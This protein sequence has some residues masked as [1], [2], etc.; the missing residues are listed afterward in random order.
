[1]PCEET[2]TRH[3]YAAQWSLSTA[4]VGSI[5]AAALWTLCSLP[6]TQKKLHLLSEVSLRFMINCGCFC[7][8]LSHEQVAWQDSG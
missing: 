6:G 7:L 5:V 1:M 8:L 4:V 2:A 3:A